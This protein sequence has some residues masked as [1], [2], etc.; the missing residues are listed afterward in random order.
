MRIEF[1]TIEFQAIAKMH[2]C[3]GKGQQ[4]VLDR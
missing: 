2:V 4:D 1:L 3:D